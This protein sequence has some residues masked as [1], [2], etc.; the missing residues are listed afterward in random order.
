MEPILKAKA[1]TF[2]NDWQTVEALFKH[3]FF[4]K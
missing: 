3:Y 4:F 2:A 1:I